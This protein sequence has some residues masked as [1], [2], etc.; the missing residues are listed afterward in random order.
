MSQVVGTIYCIQRRVGGTSAPHSG[1]S[2]HDQI[3][4]CP[5]HSHNITEEVLLKEV[6]LVY[7]FQVSLQEDLTQPSLLLLYP[8]TKRT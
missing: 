1:K 3:E 5:T 7:L 4:Y 2:N 6:L 8:F